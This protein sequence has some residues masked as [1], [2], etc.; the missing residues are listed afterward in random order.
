ML[1]LG[2]AWL[3][4]FTPPTGSTAE[5]GVTVADRAAPASRTPCDAIVRVKDLEPE[6]FLEATRLRLPALRLR[7]VERASERDPACEGA[8][9]AF[10]EL[11]ASDPGLWELTLIFSDGRAWFRT[12]PSEPDEAA[13]TLASA[14]ANLIAGIEEDDLA[15]DAEDVELPEELGEPEPAE[16][17]PAEPEPEPE[18]EPELAP[19]PEP[20]P[21]PEP[22]RPVIFE[23]APRLG[24][25]AA[26]GLSPGPGLRGLGADLG[27]DLRLP[28]GI[29]LGLD[30]R[31]LARR[32]DLLTLTRVRVRLGLGYDLRVG[33]F[34]LPVL[35]MAGVEPWTV[36]EPSKR[37]DLGAPPVLSAGLRVAPGALIQAGKLW[38]RLGVALGLDLAIEPLSGARVPTIQRPAASD[39]SFHVGGVELTAGIELALWLPV[40]ER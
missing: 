16:P 39:P 40:R 1:A 3:L 31:V 6:R 10:V 18:P 17:E 35:V 24:G 8:L 12:I 25:Q 27:L 34:E 33:R 38:L 14:L 30:L 13:R 19:E 36:R 22:E 37:F 15:P 5:A 20:E 28:Q 21:A 23:L 29:A 7:T 26:F 9:H 2:L 32:D 11:R 4:A